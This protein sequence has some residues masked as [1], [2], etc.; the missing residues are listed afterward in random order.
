MPTKRACDSV[1]HMHAR[2]RAIFTQ[3]KPELQGFRE[4]RPRARDEELNR[5]S[6]L[7]SHL[8]LPRLHLC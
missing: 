4:V 5:I 1:V 3:V 8:R 7:C 2:A 6:P